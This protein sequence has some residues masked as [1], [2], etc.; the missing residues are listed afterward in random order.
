M[1]A[2]DAK[3]FNPSKE[4]LEQSSPK[5]DNLSVKIQESAAQSYLNSEKSTQSYDEYHDV[6]EF[7]QEDGITNTRKQEI[8]ENNGI[9]EGLPFNLLIKQMDKFF[10]GDSDDSDE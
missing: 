4:D 8:F 10:F 7:I 2:I 5:K 6:H 1:A 3:L 9:V